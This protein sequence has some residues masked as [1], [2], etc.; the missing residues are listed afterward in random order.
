MKYFIII[1][2]CLLLFSCSK[3][4]PDM[5]IIGLIKPSLNHLPVQYALEN[6]P[7]DYSAFQF[8]YFHSGWET[9]EALVAG[10]IDL[11]IMPFTYIWVDVSQGKKVKIISFFERE[12]DG[13]IASEQ[14]SSLEQLND[15]RIGVL[16]NSTLEIIPEMVLNKKQLPLPEIIYF[17]TPMD[18]AVSL[19]SGEV[20]ALSF[21]VPSIFSFPDNY[22][23]IEWFS[24][25]FPL[26]TCCNL[27]ATEKALK[28]K[29]LLIQE[30]MDLLQKSITQFRDNNEKVISTAQNYYGL[31]R[32][33][34][35]RSLEHTKYITGLDKS[36]MDFEAEAAELMLKK[37]YMSR[38]IRADEV[39]Y[40]IQP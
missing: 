40:Q 38:K 32:D 2:L 13:I 26:H 10:R 37:R 34:V 35:I 9:N 12:S 30:F 19:R 27:A 1:I 20:D 29:K 3:T 23:V 4:Q 36:G 33:D 11:A 7:G 24:T 16:K 18:M 5:L 6:I 8:E 21:Y 31:K 14:F 28:L 15:A 39:Y 25:T 17:R 22:K